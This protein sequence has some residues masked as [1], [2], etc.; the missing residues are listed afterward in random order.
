MKGYS[1]DLPSPAASPPP[2]QHHAAQNHTQPPQPRVQQPKQG[3]GGRGAAPGLRAARQARQQAAEEMRGPK[4]A[5]RQDV[6]Q[7][8]SLPTQ[9]RKRVQLQPQQEAGAAAQEVRRGDGLAVEHSQGQQQRPRGRASSPQAGPPP[10]RGTNAR[11]TG[12]AKDAKRIGKLR[13]A[14]REAGYREATPGGSRHCLPP[15]ELAGASTHVPPLPALLHFPSPLHAHSNEL[16]RVHSAPASLLS[17][18][19]RPGQRPASRLRRRV[20]RRGGGRGGGAGSRPRPAERA[21]SAAAAARPAALQLVL[22]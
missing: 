10:P 14:S 2:A 4:T 8:P 21:G 12:D 19:G 18:Q 7:P 3:G 20:R 9:Q 16:L 17:C 11:V 13:A 22:R 6:Q 5:D 1:L 15:P